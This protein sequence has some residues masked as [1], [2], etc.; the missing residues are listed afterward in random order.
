MGALTLL[1]TVVYF[2]P[3][4][5]ICYTAYSHGVESEN[6]SHKGGMT[7]FFDMVFY[8]FMKSDSGIA[9]FVLACLIHA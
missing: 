3:V 1:I 5:I 4:L 9:G 2:I 6:F 7:R 8:I